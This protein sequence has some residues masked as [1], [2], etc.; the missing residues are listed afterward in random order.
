[1]VLWECVQLSLQCWLRFFEQ[2]PLLVLDTHF[3]PVC[4][5]WHAWTSLLME[6]L[7]HDEMMLF[8]EAL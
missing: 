2:L 7:R 8:M 4:T 3:T 6:K 5:L 1:M